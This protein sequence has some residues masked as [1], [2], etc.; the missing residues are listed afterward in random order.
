MMGEIDGRLTGAAAG[1]D[2]IAGFAGKEFFQH[3]PD[4]L[5]V[6]VKCRR[7]ETSVGFNPPAVLAEFH[8]IISHVSS[9]PLTRIKVYQ[10]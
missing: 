4:G 6:A 9:A 5:M 8:D 7:V 10:F 3:R 1:F 2:R